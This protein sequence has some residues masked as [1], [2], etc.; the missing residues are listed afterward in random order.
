MVTL[1]SLAGMSLE[2]L[3]KLRDDVTNILKQRAAAIED[4]LSQLTARVSH[5]MRE[6]TLKPGKLP[7]KRRRAKSSAR[8]QGANRGRPMVTAAP[9]AAKGAK[10]AAGRSA[11]SGKA[12]FKG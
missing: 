5:G 2:A 10:K 12:K 9:R 4:Q 3:V 1:K 8:S 6:P 7:P 11:T